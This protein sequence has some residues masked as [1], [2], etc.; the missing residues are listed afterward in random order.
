MLFG[1][2]TLLT[3]LGGL[4][5]NGMRNLEPSVVNAVALSVPDG[6]ASLLRPERFHYAARPVPSRSSISR[7]SQ[8]VAIATSGS[9]AAMGSG[10]SGQNAVV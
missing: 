7:E 6:E 8:A 5:A 2:S 10:V 1:P 4:R 9:S 3:T